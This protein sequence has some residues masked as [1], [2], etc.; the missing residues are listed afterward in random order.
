D[1]L[2]VDALERWAANEASHIL[3]GLFVAAGVVTVVAIPPG[4]AL[5]ARPRMLAVDRAETGPSVAG[6][7]PEP[8]GGD[9]DRLTPAL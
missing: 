2:V 9:D 5:S 3:I 7:P 6:G 8:D 1:G 4:L